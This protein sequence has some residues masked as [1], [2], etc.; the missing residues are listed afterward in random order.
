MYD[1]MAAAV[2]IIGCW[3]VLSFNEASVWPVEIFDKKYHRRD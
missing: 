2:S 3:L 1:A